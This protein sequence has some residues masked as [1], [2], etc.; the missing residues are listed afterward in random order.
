MNDNQRIELTDSFLDALMKVSEGNLGAVTAL[1]AMAKEFLLI[2]PD[3]AFG[4]LTPLFDCDVWGIYGS[5]I[6]RLWKACDASSLN[7]AALFRAV[8]LGL[9][10][11]R[12]IY[13][14]V[15][16]DAPDFSALIAKVRAELPEFA[17]NMTAQARGTP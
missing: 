14:T 2:D 1:S 17:A 13:D 16:G 8:Q 7:A 3:A 9:E 10:D 6:W 5:D 11:E 15:R 4:P 12:V